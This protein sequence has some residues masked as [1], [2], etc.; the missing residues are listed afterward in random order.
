MVAENEEKQSHPWKM[1]DAPPEYIQSQL[2]AIVGL[3]IRVQQVEAVAK[4]SQNHP[5]EN[6]LGVIN[7]L[8]Q[9]SVAEQ[10]VSILMRELEH[11]K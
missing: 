7:G 11:K 2:K 5:V 9:G 10:A 3:E 8:N 1:A 4:M 6:R